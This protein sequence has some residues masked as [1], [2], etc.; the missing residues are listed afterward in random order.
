[1]SPKLTRPGNA[2]LAAQTENDIIHGGLLEGFGP[3]LSGLTFWRL[4]LDAIAQ[5]K[6]TRL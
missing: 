3:T 4:M 1:M 2:T 5:T 6:T